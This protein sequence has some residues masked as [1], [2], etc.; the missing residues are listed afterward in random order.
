MIGRAQPPATARNRRLA[1]ARHG[2][3]AGTRN[4]AVEARPPSN[5][6]ADGDQGSGAAQRAECGEDGSGTLIAVIPPADSRRFPQG[7][8]DDDAAPPLQ[9]KSSAECPEVKTAGVPA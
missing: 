5:P 7:H 2:R 6:Q 8:S 3:C 9:P 1:M 4:Q